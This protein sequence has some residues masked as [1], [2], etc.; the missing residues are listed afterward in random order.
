[1]QRTQLIHISSANRRSG[2]PADFWVT[3]PHAAIKLDRTRGRIKVSVVSAVVNRSWYSV[4]AANSTWS[5]L[6]GS[7]TTNLTLPEGY[8]DVISLRTALAALLPGWGV[9][10]LRVTNKF[11]FQPPPDG[12]TYRFSLPGY[13]YELLGFQRGAQPTG[14]N[15]SPLV[16]Q[17]PVKLNRENS[18][19]VH[20]SLPKERGAVV[21]NLATSGFVE[22]HVLVAIPID[23]ITFAANESDMYTYTLTAQHLDDIRF[24]VTDDTGRALEL[25]YDWCL[26][27]RITYTEG[28]DAMDA[29]SSSVARGGGRAI[30]GVGGAN[31]KVAEFSAPVVRKV[32]QFARPVANAVSGIALAA[33]QPEIALLAKGVSKAADWVSGAAPKVTDALGKASAIGA[34]MQGAGSALMG[35]SGGG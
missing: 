33:G 27:L 1:M 25:Q 23:N 32:A 16:S 26:T 29:L 4:T 31:R 6:D 5:V 13:A 30:G 8:Y 12:K 10:Y 21:D 7:T 19:C 34:R 9:T 14:T 22:S 11:R 35:A 3:L 17:R 2:T 15:A 18:V 24:W 20:A 28:D